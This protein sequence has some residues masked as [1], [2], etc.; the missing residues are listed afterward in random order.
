MDQNDVFQVFFSDL[1]EECQVRMREFL[2]DADIYFQDT[3]PLFEIIKET[4]EEE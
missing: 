3:I 4:E 1:T 2:D